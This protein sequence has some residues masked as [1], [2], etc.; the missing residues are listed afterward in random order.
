LAGGLP[1]RFRGE[2]GDG[3]VDPFVERLVIGTAL[4]GPVAALI[5]DS[6]GQD[7][8]AVEQ[9]DGA[10]GVLAYGDA[11]T[12]QGIARGVSRGLGDITLTPEADPQGLGEGACMLQR[13]DAAELRN[14]AP[15]RPVGILRMCGGNRETRVV[16]FEI[17]VEEGV[18]GVDVLDV[19]HPQ[20]LGLEQPLHP[21]LGLRGEQPCSL[22]RVTDERWVPRCVVL[23]HGIEDGEQL[24]HA[25]HHRELVFFG[26]QALVMS[27]VIQ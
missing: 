26:Y 5:E 6:V 18:G 1:G 7:L 22:S 14:R 11:P 8:G 4:S 15:P 24:A 17:R 25:N 12:S 19:R 3:L 21:P 23:H 9:L 13:A 27:A 20:G 16:P 10:V 2:A